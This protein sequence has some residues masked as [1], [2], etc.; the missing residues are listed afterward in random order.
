MST[1]TSKF[2]KLSFNPKEKKF[3]AVDNYEGTSSDIDPLLEHV[4]G[5]INRYIR[6]SKLRIRPQ[7]LLLGVVL[8]KEGDIISME[9]CIRIGTEGLNMNVEEIQFT[10]WYLDRFVGALIYRPDIKGKDG[11]FGDFVI[12]NPQVVFNSL[13]ALVVKPLLELHS[14]ESS[15]QFT[16]DERKSWILRGQFTLEMITHCNLVFQ[17]VKK[18][19]LIPVENLLILLEYSHLLAK[20]TTHTARDEETTYFV[21]AILK[22]ASREELTKPPPTGID[23]PFPIKITF[24]PQYV[25]IGVFCAMI[26]ELVSRGSKSEGI[27]GLTWELVDS[28]V[29]RNLVSFHVHKA[30]KHLVTLIAHV[31]CYEIRIIRQDR[32]HTM[33]D[34]CSYVLSTILLVMKEISPLLAPIIA[35]NCSCGKL[36]FLTS[37]ADPCFTCACS[38]RISLSPQQERWFAKVSYE[39]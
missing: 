27:L 12:C 39:L 5:M 17:D 3:I 1:I 9:D 21:P 15:I 30:F 32:Y 7:M 36:C 31:D 26:S 29:K 20:I 37:E 2:G 38:K 33:H 11:Y 13:S 22:C 28:S 23:T 16:E 6:D 25:P 35:F 4:N 10:I 19:Q 8:R 34:L 24:D 18:D 14:E